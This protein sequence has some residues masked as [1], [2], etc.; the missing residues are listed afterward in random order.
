MRYSITID[1]IYNFNK[2][3]FAMGLIN[4]AKVLTRSQM[5]GKATHIQP[6]NREWVTAKSKYL[7]FNDVNL[8]PSTIFI[9]N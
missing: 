6:G 8:D 5:P 3:S 4:T 1:N 7:G 2:T 9:R